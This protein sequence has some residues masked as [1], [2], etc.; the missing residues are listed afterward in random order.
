[1]DIL[2]DYP[3]FR[4][5]IKEYSNAKTGGRQDM[6]KFTIDALIEAVQNRKQPFSKDEEKN[7]SDFLIDIPKDMAFSLCRDLYMEEI[8]R[9]IIDNHKEL[10]SILAN[11]RGMKI[12][13]L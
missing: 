1:V 6:L 4:N 13:S 11:A 3:K 2:T 5:R 9:K 12:D 8:T 7:L 10:L